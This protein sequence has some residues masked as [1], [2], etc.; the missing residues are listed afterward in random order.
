MGSFLKWKRVKQGVP[1]QK[2][3]LSLPNLFIYISFSKDS[4]TL[5]IFPLILKDCG[6][7]K[8]ISPLILKDCGE[9]FFRGGKYRRILYILFSNIFVNNIERKGV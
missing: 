7:A 1:P 8:K 2:F 4:I 6:E 3:P 9:A 5:E